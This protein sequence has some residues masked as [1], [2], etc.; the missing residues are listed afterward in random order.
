MF[1]FEESIKSK[2]T[3]ESYRYYLNR[4]AEYHKLKDLESILEFPPGDIE[5]MIKRYVIHI[6][7]QVGPNSVS[8]YIKPLKTFL[9]VN[10][11]ENK[12][13]WKQ[14]TKLYPER[15]K[16][17]GA[18]AWQ[19]EEVKKMLDTTNSLKNKAVINFLA[20]SGVR[21]G[22]VTDLKLSHITDMPD[23]CKMVLVYED[24]KDEYVTFLTPEASRAL[25]DYL[26]QR[27]SDGEMLNGDSPL[28]RS[29]YT[30]GGIKSRPSSTKSFQLIIIRA[31][32]NA[33]LRGDIKNG[34]YKT[35]A[36]HGFRKRYNTILKLNKNVNDNAI[37]KML[38]HKNGLDGV[39]LQITNEKLFEEFRAGIADLTIDP[40]QRQQVKITELETKNQRIEN[41]ERIQKIADGRLEEISERLGGRE[42]SREE[43][44]EHAM[45][46]RIRMG[47]NPKYKESWKKLVREMGISE[48]LIDRI[49]PP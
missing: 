35:Q 27:R 1:L 41:L 29:R 18:S 15:I 26:D 48:E 9:E 34:R 22:A 21:V 20:S 11:Y 31:I 42:L 46:D 5:N 28:F 32:R 25:D 4:Y 8:T 24:T 23:N 13:K 12:I 10:G 44:L 49:S 37:E 30:I 19:T 7:K 3:L 2:A 47:L 40:T 39:Y 45:L 14:I 16:L 36:V 43:S 17:S 6:K 38:G 33:N